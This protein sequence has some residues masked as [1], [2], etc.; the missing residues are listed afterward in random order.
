M[1]DEVKTSCFLLHRSSF[2][3]HRFFDP[4][5]RSRMKSE[6]ADAVGRQ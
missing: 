5:N 6:A 4:S 1:N 2:L 3:L